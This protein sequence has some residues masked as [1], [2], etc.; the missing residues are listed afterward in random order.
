MILVPEGNALRFE[1]NPTVQTRGDPLGRLDSELSSILY[2]KNFANESEKWLAYQQILERYL[3]KKGVFD[4]PETYKA[5]KVQEAD[6]EKEKI[7]NF[8]TSVM[9]QSVAKSYRSKAKEL[10]DFIKRTKNISWTRKGRVVINDVELP[11]TNIRDLLN[12][13]LSI[14]TKRSQ[15]KSTV[16]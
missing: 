8:D 9:L 15:W 12:D 2:S 16:F 5:D 7:S 13:A 14:E 10:A 1:S 3:Q 6:E 11:D 4:T